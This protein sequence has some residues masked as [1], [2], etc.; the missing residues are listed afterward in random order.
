MAKNI[1]DLQKLDL[2]DYQVRNLI[3]S[4]DKVNEPCLKKL[5]DKLLP[6]ATPIGGYTN[7]VWHDFKPND[8][9]ALVSWL[10]ENGF[11]ILRITF[12]KVG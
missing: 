3:V 8:A 5:W 4:L 9:K 11:N 12:K 10:N 1:L 6:L 2:T 7:S